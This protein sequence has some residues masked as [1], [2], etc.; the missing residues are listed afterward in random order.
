MV[1]AHLNSPLFARA[2]GAVLRGG[3]YRKLRDTRTANHQ[4]ALSQV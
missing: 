3:E 2:L 4:N 1:V